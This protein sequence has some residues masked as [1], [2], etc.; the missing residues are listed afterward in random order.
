MLQRTIDILQRNKGPSDA[1]FPRG[2]CP[3]SD[4]SEQIRGSSCIGPKEGGSR[5][6]S[7]C[8]PPETAT[9]TD[10]VWC[11][12]WQP[13]YV[14]LRSRRHAAQCAIS[15]RATWLHPDL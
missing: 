8:P 11:K 5:S 1:G 3:S 4:V 10:R 2:S 12:S 7:P 9:R 15:H 14:L 6:R 13:S